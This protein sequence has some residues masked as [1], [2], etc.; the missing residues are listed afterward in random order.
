M[1]AWPL[2]LP[3]A[4]HLFA[5]P[6]RCLLGFLVVVTMWCVPA[7]AAAA[8]EVPPDIDAWFAG[9]AVDALQGAARG[10]EGARL[11][12]PDGSRVRLGNPR[13]VHVWQPAFVHGG[14]SDRAAS[15]RPAGEWIAPVY[16]DGRPTTTVTAWRN[17][18]GQVELATVAAYSDLAGVL[19]DVPAGEWLVHEAPADAWFATSET[20]VRPLNAGARGVLPGPAS[21]AEYGRIV[22]DAYRAD[23]GRPDGT[24]LVGGRGSTGVVDSAG[25]PLA[26]PG[27]VGALAAGALALAVVRRRSRER[28]AG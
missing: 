1:I 12:V 10:G 25:P 17:P 20:G 5:R 27:L 22:A 19:A 7:P 13:A 15:V 28:R 9:P 11:G 18:D 24:D 3:A 2:R 26:L 14:G 6:G 8:Q 21:L 16:V 4:W 23:R